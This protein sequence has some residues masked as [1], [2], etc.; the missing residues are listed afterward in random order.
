M[1]IQCHLQSLCILVLCH[2]Q[3]L[4]ILIQCRLQSLSILVC[5][6]NGAPAESWGT[7]SC[8]ADRAQEHIWLVAK[9]SEAAFTCCVTIVIH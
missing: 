6:R 3:S 8:L 7:H 9:V 1:C 5:T 4:C 2:L